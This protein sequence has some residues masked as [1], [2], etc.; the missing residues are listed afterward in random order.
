MLGSFSNSG[1]GFGLA[2]RLEDHFSGTADEIQRAMQRLGANTNMLEQKVN[3]SMNQMRMG[4]GLLS[5][6]LAA[7]A[8]IVNGAKIQAEFEQAEIGLTTILGSAE[9]AKSVFEVIKQQAA[10][11]PF[12]TKDLLTA[13][14]AIISQGIAAERSTEVVINLG[15]ALSAMGKSSAEL[16]SMAVNLQQIA[17]VGEASALDMKQFAFQGINMYALVAENLGKT[18]EEVQG[19]DITFEMIEAALAKAGAEG[20]RFAGAME[21]MSQSVSGK[22]STLRDNID[23]AFASLGKAVEPLTHKLLDFGLKVAQSLQK[24]AESPIGK[25]IAQLTVVMGGFAVILG[26]VLLLVGAS[27]FAMYQ[28]ANAFAGETKATLIATFA[29]HGFGASMK[30]L[31]RATWTALAP[32]LPF[33]AIVGAVAGAVYLVVTAIK[34]GVEAFNTLDRKAAKPTGLQLFLAKLGGVVQVVKD[35]WNTWNGFTFSLSRE[36]EERLKKLGIYETAIGIATWILRV[37]EMLKGFVTGFTEGFNAV[38]EVVVSVFTTISNIVGD[39]LAAFGIDIKKNISELEKWKQAGKIFGYVLVGVLTALTVAFVGFAAAQIVAFAPTILVIGAVVAAGWL[40]YKAFTYIMQ[41]AKWVW[42]AIAPV[43]KVLAALGN[44]IK[45]VVVAELKFLWA[46]LVGVATYIKDAVVFIF[47]VLYTI[48]KALTVPLIKL[49]EIFWSYLKP[50]LIE[51]YDLIA[52]YVIPY[53]NFLGNVATSVGEAIVSLFNWV[54]DSVVRVIEFLKGAWE[55]ISGLVSFIGDKIGD[56]YSMGKG[57][58]F[59]G[60]DQ[61][62]QNI[63]YAVSGLDVLKNNGGGVGEKTAALRSQAQTNINNFINPA[64]AQPTQQAPIKL[65]LDGREIAKSVNEAN[66]LSTARQ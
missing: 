35:V 32:L 25:F 10:A 7:L 29:T 20:G 16:S 4:A 1:L 39:T 62:D 17:A 53:F 36:T 50:T 56:V 48:V 19:M 47:K 43:R 52:S 38:K 14:Q 65:Y 57:A 44:L 51:I 46:V 23:F 6:G 5:L 27:R 18:Q 41:A 59:S 49:Y 63:N 31:A 30:A 3:L 66:K 21:K 26:T 24:L 13:N 33:I 40:L 34:K 55:W 45:D 2:F 11:T 15:N 8:P 64:N 58:I 42:E 61:V 9:K 37:K 60:L 54:Y 28:L 12:Q 22:L